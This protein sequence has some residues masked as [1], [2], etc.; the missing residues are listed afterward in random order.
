MDGSLSG[1]TGW[2]FFWVEEILEVGEGGTGD[3]FCDVG[4]SISF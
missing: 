3:D 2:R 1:G 4:F